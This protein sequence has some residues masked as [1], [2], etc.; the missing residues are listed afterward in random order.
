M[1]DVDKDK[2]TMM[3]ICLTPEAV[4]THR[5]RFKR[6]KT[7]KKKEEN[8]VSPFHTTTS[9]QKNLTFQFSDVISHSDKFKRPDKFGFHYSKIHLQEPSN[10]T[11]VLDSWWVKIPQYSRNCRTSKNF[12]FMNLSKGWKNKK[13]FFYQGRRTFPPALFSTAAVTIKNLKLMPQRSS[14]VLNKWEEQW[15]IS[16]VL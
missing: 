14:Y 5:R 13:Y 2:V 9:L 4:W 8:K 10:A 16:K 11:H 3:E 15:K 7:N 6:S 1:E 12:E